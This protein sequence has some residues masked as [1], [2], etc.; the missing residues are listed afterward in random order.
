MN[1]LWSLIILI[2][3]AS[4]FSVIIIFALDEIL[5]RRSDNARPPL[6]IALSS[7]GAVGQPKRTSRGRRAAT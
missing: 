7:T 6:A 2:W 5:F 4:G 1:D 3:G